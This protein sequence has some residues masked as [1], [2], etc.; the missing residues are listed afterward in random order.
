MYRTHPQTDK[1]RELIKE[2][3]KDNPIT[4]EASFGF[5][6]QVPEEH[7]L[8]NPE[9][10]GGS[11][12]D[13][14][15]YPMSMSRMIIGEQNGKPF[16]NP[17]AI[18]AKGELSSRGVDLNATAKLSFDNGS[19]A[20]ISSAINKPLKILFLLLMKKNLYTLQNL[21]NVVNKTIANLRL[22]T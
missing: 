17:V 15:C 13:I 21:G 16:S 2:E 1:I 18:E 9:L 19:K 3:F 11:I 4:I 10:G 5:S 14:G 12:M 7:R 6:A 22:F 8:V 20:F